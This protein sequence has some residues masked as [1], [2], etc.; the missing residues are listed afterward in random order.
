MSGDSEFGDLAIQTQ[1]QQTRWL[2]LSN[3]IG[4]GDGNE[5]GVGVGADRGTC[6]G[7]GRLQRHCVQWNW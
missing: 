5:D 1:T 6:S 7:H 3:V 4:D 2:W